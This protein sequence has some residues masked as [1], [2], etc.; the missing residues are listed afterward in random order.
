MGTIDIVKS[1]LTQSALEALCEK[2]YIPDVVHHV[3]PGHNDRIRNSPLV[4]RVSHFEILCCVHGFVPIVDSLK[5]WNDHFFWVDA[6]VFPLAIP[7]HN[8]K[9]LRED[10]HPTPAE[11]NVDECN[12]VTDNPAPFRTFSEPFLCFVGISR[13][14]DLD[15]NCYPTF[16]ANDDEG[17]CSLLASFE[18]EVSLLQLTGDRVFPLAGVNDQEDRIDVVVDDEVQAIVADKRKRIS[19][20]PV[21]VGVAVTAIV[22]FVTSSVTYDS[23]FGTR[24]RTRHPAE[25]FVI[26]SESSHDLNVNDIDDEVTSVIR[27]SMPPPP[28]LTAAV[29][30]TFTTGVTSA[31]VHGSGAGQAQH[32]IF[33]DLTSPNVVEADVTGPSQCVGKELLVCFSVEI[34]M[35]FEYELRGRQRFEGK[36]AMQANWLKERNAEI[37]SLIAQLSL[38]EAKATEAIRLCDQVVV[39]EATEAARANVKLAF[40][41]AQVAKLTQDLSRLQLS[42]DELS[43]KASS[44]EFE[45]D[46]LIDQVSALETTCSGLRDEVMAYKLLK[47]Q[48]EAMQDEQVKALGDRVAAI[49]SDLMEMALHMEEEFYP[50]WVIGRVIDKGMQDGLAAS[51]DHG[52]ARRGLVDVSACNPFAEADYVTAINALRVGDAK[53]HRLSLT[54]AMVPLIEPLSAKSLIGETSA[55]GVSAMVMT[56]ALSTTFIQAN[57]IPS[58]PSSEVP[59]SPKV[60]FE[61]EELDTTPEHTSAPKYKTAQELWAAI[62]KTF[63]G[64]EATKKTK[65]N[66]L[67]QQYGNFK[68]EGSETLEQTFNRLQVIVSQLQ[69]DLDT[70][71]LDDLYNHLKVY[72]SEVQKKSEPNSQ[73]MAFISSAKHSSGNKEVNI[74]SVSTASINVSTASANIGVASISQDAACAYI[75]SQ[76]SGSQIKFEDINQINEDDMEEMDIKWNMALLSMRADRFWK[77]TGKKI[78]IQGTDV[79][80]FDKSKVECFNCHKMGH[81]ARECR[82][83]RS[84]DRGRRDN[85]KQ[86]SKV[87]E[88]APKAL[89]AID[90]VGCDWSYMANDEENH[91]LVANE[92]DPT[93]FA[94]M[95]KTD[96]ESETGLP[97]FKDD[98]VTNY[99]RPS[100]AIES[101]LDDAQNRN[102]SEASPST[103]LPKSFIKFMKANDSPTKSKT[104]KVKT[105]KKPP[106]KKFPTVN[107][108]LPTINRKFPTGNTKFST[109]DMGNKG[110]AGSSQNNIDDKGYWNSGCS[111]HMTC[112]ISYLSNYEP[113]DGGYVSFGQGGCKITGKG[114]IK[115]SK[116]EFEN[117]YFVKD[118]KYN[119][120]SVSQICDNKNSVLFTD[121]E[122]IVLGRDFKLIDDTNM[123]LMTPR[124]HNMYYIDLNNSVP[125]KDLTRLVA[126]A[127]ADECMLWHRRLGHLNFKTMNR[128]VRHNLVRGLPSKCFEN[129]HTCTACLKGKQHKASC[130]SKLVNFVTKPL[131]TLHMDL[132]GL[133]SVSSISHKWV[134]VNKSQNKTPYELFNGRTPAIGFL[135]PFGCHVMILNTLD[136]LGKFEAKGDEGYFIGYSMSSKVFRVF[137]KR[138]KRVEENLHVDFLENKAIKKGVGPNW[139]FDMDSLTKSMNYV[140]VVVAGTNSTNFSG[141]KDAARQE[142]KKDVSSLRYIAL[143]NLIHE[144][145]LESSSSQPQETC[146]S[147]EPESSGNS[148]LTATSTNPPIDQLETL[149]VETPI[150]TISSP[151]LTACLNDSPEP[152]KEGWHFS[153]SRQ[154]CRGYPQE[155]WIFRCQIIKYSH[156]QGE[157]LGKDGTGKDVDLHLYRSMIGSLMYLTASRPDIMFAICAC[158]RHQVTPKECHLHAVKRIFR[159]L[160][161]HPKLGLWYP[162]ESPFDLT[163]MATSTTEAEY[164]A[165]ASGCGQVLWIQNQLLDYGL[166]MPCKALSKEISSS[167]LLLFHT[168]KTFGLVW[169]WLGGDYGNVFLMGISVIMARLAF[170]DYHNMIAI[171][172][173]SEHNIDF[174]PIVDF[175]EASPLSSLPDAELFKNLTLMG[176]NISPNQKFTFQKGQFSHQWKYLIHTIMQCL[177]PKSTGFNEFSSNIATALVWLATNR[178]YNFS[179]MIF[180]GMGEGSGIPT[181]PHHTPSLEAQQTSPTTYSSPTLLPVTT[182]NITPVIPTAP[183]PT[184]VPTDTPQL[185]HYTRRARIAQSSALPPVVDEANIAKTSALPHES[186]SRVPSLAADEGSLQL[187]I[188]ELTDLCTSLQRQHS[189]LVSK[190]EAQ[191][192]E[193]TMLKAK[194]KL[195]EDRQG[196]VA[197]RSRDDAPIKGRRLDEGE[198]AAKKGS[199]DTE[200]MINVLTSMDAAT[201][202][203]SG[204]AKV[205]TGSG[206]I[207]T[208]GP[209]AAE[210]PIGSD[211]VPIAGPIF[212]TA[213]VVTPYTR[214]KGKEKMIE[215]ETPKKKKIQEQMD[216]QMAGQLEEEMEREAQRMNEQISRDTEIARIHAEEELQIMIDGLDRSNETVAKYQDNY[217]KVYKYQSQQRKPLTKKQQ[218]EFNTSVL[219]NQAGL[220]AKDFKGMTLEEIK[221]NFNTVWKKIEEFIPIGS[222]EETERF[223]RKGLR[224]EQV[225]EKKLKT[226]EEVLE[227]V[228]ATEE[229]PED[230]VKE[231]M[232]LVPVE[233]VYVEA[234]QVKHP[235]I[236]WKVHKEGQRSYWK[237]TRLGGSSASYQ[238]FVDML[239]HLDREDL[240]QL[241]RLVKESLSIR[242]PTSDKEME[243]WVELKRLYEPDD[244]DQIWTHT[245][246]LM[247]ASIE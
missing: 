205:P 20:L 190:F 151:V 9:T 132:F 27:S 110:K 97:E 89:M 72:E 208:A 7:W 159:Y 17:G 59:P 47:E 43:V 152:S 125:Y 48:V 98:T 55:S 2:Y 44:L 100:P 112:N 210:V 182:A 26:S 172:E 197:E 146:N 76:S 183:L 231:M 65:K 128:L 75:A 189:D 120:F 124:Q 68:A 202:L 185:R 41:H 191:E 31:P 111:R 176:Y 106:V 157:S 173:K 135:K 62:L 50:C 42:C 204:V 137:N 245:Q 69:R 88:H 165:A 39:V 32:S 163:I 219:R 154:V 127:S 134:L 77:K 78:R 241:W 171:L 56:T 211:V 3:L 121:S 149:T 214:R 130:K 129:D 45:K 36:C 220:K 213:T 19:H 115:T 247:H 94:L 178:V 67:K 99:S 92:K 184:V 160:T 86:R 71:S 119:L 108:K 230:K 12:Y 81:F 70:M 227:E 229:V 60:V 226:S 194:V 28:E 126:K 145:H 162:K 141:T 237:I 93:E 40:S 116:L 244:E 179:K 177:S 10:P 203:S 102:P 5:N 21:E 61:Q 225:S 216:I 198:E 1:I 96:A 161:G 144:V 79:V 22:P 193:I 212:A 66:L 156:G 63:G 195:L 221:E 143:P 14:Y 181:E 158:T 239:K 222:K 131:H 51:I 103:I 140:P 73:N 23:I 238:F 167:I 188:Q 122:C 218:R 201:V 105:A 4:A 209:P 82:A 242:P 187:R 18:R 246:N 175:V 16:W 136:N 37:A 139:L 233:E 84:Q 91:A 117:V 15:E 11:F 109:V 114:I 235:I 123:L 52:K 200:E 232:Q 85:Y 147:D 90:E 64:N 80:G 234:L 180:D 133:T 33:R 29:A 95:A 8:D 240:N 57:T 30:T 207:P 53:A 199:N 148:N 228:K 34:K 215:S 54:D 166:S 87:E 170:C 25:R 206:S 101:T 196:G 169:I 46:K 243:L 74:A 24:L 104:D 164:V 13:Y 236:D 113:F 186:T 192:L 49:D 217:A 153:L 118:L 6:S 174:H 35:R 58:V 107:R 150:P 138:T 38:K 223:K 224:L 142:V 155:I 168:A 83:P